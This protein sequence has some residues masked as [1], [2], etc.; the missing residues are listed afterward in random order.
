M[1]NVDAVLIQA[2]ALLVVSR[3]ERFL[4]APAEAEGF[5]L[6]GRCMA[7]SGNCSNTTY[8]GHLML[9]SLLVRFLRVNFLPAAVAG[10][11][12]RATLVHSAASRFVLPIGFGVLYR[13]VSAAHRLLLPVY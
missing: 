10:L 7:G 3:P 4:N 1:P 6:P 11:S 9:L 12:G 2:A 5:F 13:L 8:V